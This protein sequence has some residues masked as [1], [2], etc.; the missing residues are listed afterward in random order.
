MFS[1]LILQLHITTA[2]V[3]KC[4]HKHSP[5]TARRSS[6]AISVKGII[7][8]YVYLKLLLGQCGEELVIKTQTREINFHLWFGSTYWQSCMNPCEVVMN[9][10]VD[11]VGGRSSPMR[12]YCTLRI[13]TL[14]QLHNKIISEACHFQ[15][16]QPG[17]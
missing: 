13:W 16:T 6:K 7:I 2:E 17:A 10:T 14:K 8:S 9:W 12:T 1:L 15:Q 3:Q 4:K 5:G 11:C